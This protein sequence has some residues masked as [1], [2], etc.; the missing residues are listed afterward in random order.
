MMTR[1]E[2]AKAIRWPIWIW[3]IGLVNVGAMLP[4][5]IAI[6]QTWSVENLSLGMYIIY[7]VVQVGFCLEG[8]FRRNRMMFW[9]MGLS[10]SVSVIIITLILYI[11]LSG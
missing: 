8:F 1:E 7:L 2:F 10:A 5:L 6:L 4:Q 11:R 9:T 3:L